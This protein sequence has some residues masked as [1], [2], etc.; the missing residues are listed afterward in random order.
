MYSTLIV[1]DEPNARERIRALLAG[2]ESIRIIGECANGVEALGAIRR[3]QPQLLLL[4]IQMPGLDGF[5]VLAHLLPSEIPVTVFITAYDQHAIRAFDVGAVD[6]VL[7]PIVA[8]RFHVAVARAL[9]RVQATAAARPDLPALL[10]GACTSV[11]WLDRLVLEKR[12]RMVMVQL[13]DVYWLEAEGNYVRVHAVDGSYLMRATLRMLDSRLDPAH[14]L[15]IH[16][17]AIVSLQHVDSMR[18]GIHGDGMVL[19]RNGAEVP[20]SRTRAGQLRTL[21]RGNH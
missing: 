9:E 16:R 15:R 18:P 17:S 3:D 8:E 5:G 21:L 2:H 7:K 12:G 11:P 14:F 10:R 4:D 13:D 19:M 20:A 1:D 6:Y